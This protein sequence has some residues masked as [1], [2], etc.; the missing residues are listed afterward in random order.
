MSASKTNLGLVEHAQ[1]ALSQNWGYTLGTWGQILTP[2]I[3]EQ[4]RKQL[5]D[6]IEQYLDFIKEHWLGQRTVDCIGLFKSYLWWTPAG[7]IYD[8]KTDLN[9]DGTYTAA[10]VKGPISSIPEKIIGLGV[11]KP[12]HIGIY[13]GNGWVIESKGTK[14]G[15]VKTPLKGSGATAWTH[16]LEYPF[17]EYVKE[18]SN[19]GK[20]FKDVEDS[21]WSAKHIEAA[22]KLDLIAGNKDGTF[23]PTGPLTREQAAVLMVNLYEKVT[24]KKVL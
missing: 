6:G 3:L 2:T 8:S 22:K 7:P 13:I 14:Y 4:K 18:E 5:G 24:G 9:A 23:N 15:V 11:R 12:G 17:I 19:V 20:A 16:W 21:R 10:K 1:M